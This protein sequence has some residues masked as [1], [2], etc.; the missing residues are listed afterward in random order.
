MSGVPRLPARFALTL[1]ARGTAVSLFACHP[2]GGGRLGGSGGVPLPHCQLPFQFG[3]LPLLFGD[4][5]LLFGDLLISFD[6][7]LTEFLELPL[8]PFDFPP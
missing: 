5:P 3:D 7:L 2:I 1:L 6:Y 4:L 8:L